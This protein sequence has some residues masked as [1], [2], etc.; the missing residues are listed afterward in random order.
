LYLPW[1]QVQSFYGLPYLLGPSILLAQ[2]LAAVERGPRPAVWLVRVAC[3]LILLGT[4]AISHRLATMSFAQR[5]HQFE[6]ARRVAAAAPP[7]SI[8]FAVRRLPPVAWEGPGPTLGRYAAATFGLPLPPAADILCPDVH[9]LRRD[10]LPGVLLISV[11]YECGTI[12]PPT[13]V[14]IEHYKYVDWPNFGVRSDS[15]R[16]DLWPS[17]A[18][19]DSR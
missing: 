3:L 10:E 7:D 1:P 14:V 5:G 2:G 9:R 16:V 12:A 15:I 4:A 19:R 13:D 6:L 11:S 17:A 8:L 18:L